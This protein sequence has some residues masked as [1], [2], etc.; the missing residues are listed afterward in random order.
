MLYS[1]VLCGV[2]VGLCGFVLRFEMLCNGVMCCAVLRNTRSCVVLRCAV[3]CCN[4]VCC[5]V[6]VWMCVVL[7]F[8]AS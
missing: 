5:V 2:E 1:V 7:K 4:A 6:T 8:N 3:M